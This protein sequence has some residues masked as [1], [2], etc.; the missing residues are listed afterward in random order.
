M[1]NRCPVCESEDHKRIGI[2]EPDQIVKKFL[3]EDYEIVMCNS[4]SC[5]YVFPDISFDKRTWNQIYSS[6][7]FP[8]KTR[9]YYKN[10]TKQLKS[11]FNKIFLLLG[12]KSAITLLDVGSGEGFALLESFE[13][14]WETSGID[15][16]DNRNDI[17]KKRGI[18]F[19][20]GY[21]M[22]SNF[23]AD[24]FDIVYVDSVLEHVVNPKEYLTKMLNLLTPNGIIYL[25]VPNED[26]LF[27]SFKKMIYTLLRKPN[28][29]AQLK[30]FRSPYHVV[31][32]NKKSLTY[33][34]RSVGGE[35]VRMENTGRKFE[36][37]G[38]PPTSL[39]FWVDLLFLFPIEYLGKLL[40]KDLYYEVYLTKK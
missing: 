16:V 27:N 18:K 13:R 26:S 39:N 7:Y 10:R 4:C 1:K 23:S 38:S 8:Q 19:L 37:L 40:A 35:I 34:I 32:F 36:F 20:E 30:P 24:S 29:S 33:L 2:S 28:V 14:G 3:A 25:G 17:A 6:E 5:Y 21:F 12:S 31:G 15:I 9:W 11:R 22:E